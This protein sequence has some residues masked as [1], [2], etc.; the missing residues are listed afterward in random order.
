LCNTQLSEEENVALFDKCAYPNYHGHNYDL[1]VTVKGN[2]NEKSGY[3]M[4]LKILSR[5]MKERVINKLD[6]RNLNLD[7]D[8][9]KDKIT[10]TENILLS[11]WQQL[12]EPI[13]RTGCQLHKI[14][15]IETENNYAEYYGE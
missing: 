1:I 12:E 8:F 10:T 3:V 2:I 11:I 4:D 9:L 15:L 6:H 14:K 7:V 13:K 5:I